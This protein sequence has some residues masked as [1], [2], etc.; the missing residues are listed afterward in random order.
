MNKGINLRTPNPK[1]SN[2]VAKDGKFIYKGRLFAEGSI[3]TLKIFG[4]QFNVKLVYD[5]E[6]KMLI[7]Q[8]PGNGLW[9]NIL[10]YLDN[11]IFK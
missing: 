2:Q 6:K 4:M 5:E 1:L 9:F 3:V 10:G 11:I 7:F 8:D